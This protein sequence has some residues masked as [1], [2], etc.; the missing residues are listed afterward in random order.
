MNQTPLKQCTKMPSACSSEMKWERAIGFPDFWVSEYGDVVKASHNRRLKGHLSFDGY[1]SYKL[2]DKEGVRRHISA[3]RLVALAFIGHPPSENSQVA[4]KNG[5]RLFCHPS[6]LMWATAK[7]NHADRR[8][9]GTGP[10]GE[11]N[12]KAK[13]TEN[14]VLEIRRT[15]RDIKEGRLN[16][17][18]KE[19]ADLYGIHHATLCAISSG[20]LWKHVK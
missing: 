1:P 6:N 12:P 5:S 10:A 11:S 20:K 4:H 13:L 16:M 2:K 14:D 18:V 9:H 8:R 3:H 15:H 7:E 19:L 17:K